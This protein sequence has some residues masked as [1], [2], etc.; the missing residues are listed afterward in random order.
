LIAVAA[1]ADRAFNQAV[2]AAL[3][4]RSR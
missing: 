4:C 3:T 2:D 1:V